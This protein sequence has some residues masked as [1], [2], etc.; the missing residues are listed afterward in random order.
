MVFCDPL[1]GVV[2]IPKSLVPRVLQ[3]LPG[4]VE[5]D[6]LVK[7]DVTDGRSVKDAF[8]EHRSKS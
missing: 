3:I 4:L 8:E 2:V 6:D 5:V 1:E 7:G